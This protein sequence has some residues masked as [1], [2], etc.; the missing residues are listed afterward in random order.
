MYNLSAN[1]TNV[2]EHLQFSAMAA[3]GT[4]LTHQRVR[5]L[6]AIHYRQHIPRQKWIYAMDE[7]GRT[8]GVPNMPFADD[9]ETK[10]NCP[11]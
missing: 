4:S 9:M 3:W 2:I 8:V 10:R 7:H 6:S 1:L 5:M 11:Y